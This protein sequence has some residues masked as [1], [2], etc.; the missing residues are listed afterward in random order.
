M[1]HNR[2]IWVAFFYATEKRFRKQER[3]ILGRS[4]VVVGFGR[5]FKPSA[6]FRGRSDEARPQ[7]AFQ[8]ARFAAIVI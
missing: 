2:I 3:K 8:R 7:S 1:Y 5:Q 6:K 4:R